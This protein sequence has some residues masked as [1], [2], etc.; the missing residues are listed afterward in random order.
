MRSLLYSSILS[1]VAGLDPAEGHGGPVGETQGEDGGG[2]VRAEGDDTGGPADLHAGLNEL[3]G[4]RGGAFDV[5]G[6]TE[7]VEV[8]LLVFQDHVHGFLDAGGGADDGGEPGGGAVYELDA[9]F[10]EDGVVGRAQP[11][12]GGA[13]VNDFFTADV[14]IGV[15][16]VADG[17]KDLFGDEGG[18]TGVQAGSQVGQVMLL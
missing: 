18:H 4:Y 11:D 2:D 6:R 17:L 8:L 7:D 16:Q 13:F 14:E 9:A 15:F 5:P 12:I 10:P 1:A 3:L